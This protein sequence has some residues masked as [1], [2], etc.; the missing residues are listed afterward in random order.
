MGGTLLKIIIC[1]KSGTLLGN[2]LGGGSR[3]AP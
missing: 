1:I 3:L 2:V